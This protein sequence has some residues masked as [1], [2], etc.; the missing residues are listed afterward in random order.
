[1]SPAR[2]VSMSGLSAV[3]RRTTQRA[4]AP[5]SPSSVAKPTRPA[6]YR[7]AAVPFSDTSPRWKQ[8]VEPTQGH[9]THH[10]ELHGPDELDEEVRQWL[11]QAWKAG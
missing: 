2:V 11:R 10:L 7:F 1:M 9:F 4:R 6:P 8:V 5:G 3:L